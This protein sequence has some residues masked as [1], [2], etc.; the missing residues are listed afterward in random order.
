[1]ANIQGSG[2]ILTSH[3]W[4]AW[5]FQQWTVLDSTHPFF[6]FFFILLACV[7]TFM[8]H[9]VCLCDTCQFFSDVFLNNFLSSGIDLLRKCCW[10]GL[11]RGFKIPR[12]CMLRSYDKQSPGVSGHRWWHELFKFSLCQLHG[13][14]SVHDLRISE[15]IYLCGIE[16]PSLHFVVEVGSSQDPRPREGG[17]PKFCS[18]FLVWELLGHSLAIEHLLRDFI[19]TY[20]QCAA[21]ISKSANF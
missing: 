12:W 9:D 5:D 6:F 15:R 4:K 1:M 14:L 7:E 16:V 18:R 19:E 17:S 11:R 20:L 13:W 2:I 8:T 3:L 21:F 10:E